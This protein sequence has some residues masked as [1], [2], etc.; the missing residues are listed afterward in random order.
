VGYGELPPAGGR[1]GEEPEHFVVEEVPAYTPSGEGEHL[2]LWVEKRGLTTIEVARSLARRL[3][4]PDRDVGFAGMKDKNAI[5]RQWFSTP[6]PRS[7]VPTEWGLGE[8]LRVLEVSRHKNKL[9][10]GHLIANRFSVTLVDVPDGGEARAR[11]IVERLEASGL[12]NAFGPQRFGRGG[13]NLEEALSWLEGKER[14]RR[15]TDPKLLASVVQSEVFNRYLEA[16]LAHGAP[17]LEGE[18][19]R[20]E[21]TGSHFVVE[22]VAREL[23]RLLEGDLHRTG[24]LLGP[25]TL[26]ATAA[27]REL[28]QRATLEAGLGEAHLQALAAHAPGARRD[29]LLR[30]QGL[31]LTSPATGQLRLDFTLPAGA[32]ATQLCRELTHAPWAT[33]H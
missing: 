12:P 19:V 29:L 7:E 9:R 21:G 3:G 6:A 18:V 5:T 33:A 1:I 32:F 28:E 4:V 24:P 17:L 10:T 16:R 13:Q 27:A 14:P 2:Y 20:L 22:E 31:S 26:Q 8:Q 25:R 11:A 15:G 23:P 30:P